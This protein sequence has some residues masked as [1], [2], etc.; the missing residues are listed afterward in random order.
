MRDREFERFAR[1]HLLPRLEGFRAHRWLVYR[2]P[3]STILQA[4]AFEGSDI[5]KETAYCW[6]FVQPLYVPRREVVFTFGRRLI[7]GK[8][9]LRGRDT[10]EITRTPNVVETTSMVRAMHK[11][12]PFFHR[13]ATPGKVVTNLAWQTRAFRNPFV[14]E[15]RAY[16]L[17]RLGQ[18]R[19]AERKLRGLVADVR[20]TD[21]WY[22]VA[23]RGERLLT[24]ISK[25]P[26]ATRDLL[27]R[28]TRETA[29]NLG[30]QAQG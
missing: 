3:I 28:W 2:E 20:P 30:L 21:P 9:F 13:L 14:R 27:D 25:G 17:A 26:E 16:S 19:A 4:F 6:A 24:A 23:E 15:A 12:L 7:N 8:G 11:A 29:S 5:S 18:S 22:E 10:W 1:T